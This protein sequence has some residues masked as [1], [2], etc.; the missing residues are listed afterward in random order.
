MIRWLGLVVAL[1]ACGR[2]ASPG[3]PVT[4]T[5]P[6]PRCSATT[7]TAEL[8]DE[9][10]SNVVSLRWPEEI[11][12][13]VVDLAAAR[14]GGYSLDDSPQLVPLR[15]RLVAAPDRYIAT[16]SAWFLGDADPRKLMWAY[17]EHFLDE[18]ARVRPAVVPDLRARLRATLVAAAQCGVE[19]EV[20]YRLRQRVVDLD[21]ARPAGTCGTSFDA[22]TDRGDPAQL[23]VA[24]MTGANW[25]AAVDHI[26]PDA[27]AQLRAQLAADP[28]AAVALFKAWFLGADAAV[29]MH[30]SHNL[31]SFLLELARVRPAEV[32]PL[33]AAA[34]AALERSMA[35]ASSPVDR[36]E[37]I[38]QASGLLAPVRP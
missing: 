21:Q 12:R 11:E 5:S 14:A 28:A 36:H 3:G 33:R 18:V 31:R 9:V 37:L 16:F 4:P 1:A 35:C 29:A 20:A 7:A 15:A 6:P 27:V 13:E 23:V 17:P 38:V 8:Q 25:G 30:T 34:L 10:L 22:V 32:E 26:G 19:P 2:A 24:S